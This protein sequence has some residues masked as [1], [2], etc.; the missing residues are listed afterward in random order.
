MDSHLRSQMTFV[1]FC[2]SSF[3]MLIVYIALDESFTTGSALTAKSYHA[4]LENL[5]ASLS[6]PEQAEKKVPREKDC[7]PVEHL[8]FLP[9]KRTKSFLLQSIFIHFGLKNHLSFAVPPSSSG[10][11]RNGLGHQFAPMLGDQAK[12]IG[13]GLGGVKYDMICHDM[14]LDAA[15]V[16]ELMPSDTKFIGLV[17]DPVY[18]FKALWDANRHKV[19]ESGNGIES[20]LVQHD[21]NPTHK[22]HSNLS[23]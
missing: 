1:F 5:Q 3:V 7:L 2:C 4:D 14:I 23:Q 16:Y 20:V 19:M 18:H 13:Y 11:F 21:R 6:M 22:R 15:K 8:A 17:R 10:S 9:M 12:I